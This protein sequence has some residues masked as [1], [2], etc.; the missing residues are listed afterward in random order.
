MKKLVCTMLVLILLICS[1]NF[2]VLAAAPLPS[3][4]SDNAVLMNAETGEILYGKNLDSTFAPASTTKLM[5]ALL[6]LE[7]CS[8]DDKVTVSNDFLSKNADYIDGNKIYIENGEQTS[9][10]DLLYSLLL[11]S[12]NDSAVALADHISGSVPEFAKKMNERA[13]E[14][15][16]TNTNFM[17][18]NGLYDEKHLSSVKDLS[19]IMKELL[20]HPEYSKISTTLVY[21]MSPTNKFDKTRTEKTRKFWNEDKLLYKQSSAYYEG[22]LGGKAGYTIKSFHSFV[23]SAEKNNMSLIV[24][25]H[26][27]NKTFY[28]DTRT[29]LDYGFQNFQMKKLFSKGD[30][31]TNYYIKGNKIPLIAAEDYY[32][33]TPKDSKETPDYTIKKDAITKNKFSKGEK[34]LDLKLTL[35]GQN[36]PTLKLISGANYSSGKIGKITSYVNGDIYLICGSIGVAVVLIAVFILI[37]TIRARKNKRKNIFYY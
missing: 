29:L 3:I 25:F 4:G 18:P 9:V 23:A 19:L 36:L 13:K 2:K 15:G 10:K 17:N 34:L 37:K 7:N 6:T 31:V 16:C 1:S 27:K 14:L 33:I 21:E 22:V 30:V 20:K 24:A 11:M 35:N 32:Y 12:A 26:G 8:L 28:E 5:T